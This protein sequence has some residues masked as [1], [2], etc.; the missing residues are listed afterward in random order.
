MNSSQYS[1]PHLNDAAL[2]RVVDDMHIVPLAMSLVHLTG[3]ASVLDAIAPHV[4]G[5]W[6][7]SEKV[8]PE[9]KRA[10]RDRMTRALIALRD[11]A[12]RP[13][14]PSAA[15]MQRML[16]VAVSDTVAPDYLPMIRVQMGIGSDAGAGRD[17]PRLAPALGFEVVVIGA[18]VS[19]IGLGIKL[20]Q[21][22]VAFEIL[23]KNDEVGGTWL[24][25]SYPGC[26]VDTPNHF[27]QFSFEPND[28]WP[29]YYSRQSAILDYLRL[30]ADKYGVREHVR[31]GCEARGARWDEATGTWEVRYTTRMGEERRVRANVLVTAARSSR[32]LISCSSPPHSFPASLA[33]AAWLAARTV[34]PSLTPSQIYRSLWGAE[35]PPEGDRPISSHLPSF[36]ADCVSRSGRRVASGGPP[37][38]PSQFL[39]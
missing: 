5:P 25:N 11:R 6:D 32:P 18:G 15:L 16:D 9:T 23:E 1:G 38:T 29:N 14:E 7:Y 21:A 19:G 8:P 37:L 24:E 2:H 28:D 36:S 20:R 12:L 39:R 13:I 22:G 30:C 33:T 26:A 10:L 27:Y 35:H 4:H 3:D 31:F 34:Q 17:A